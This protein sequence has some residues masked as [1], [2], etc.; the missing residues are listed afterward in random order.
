MEV[1]GLF[2]NGKYIPWKP[3]WNRYANGQLILITN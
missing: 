3:C 2:Y 1:E